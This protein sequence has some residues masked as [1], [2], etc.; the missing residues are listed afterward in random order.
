M[1]TTTLSGH[2]V[3]LRAGRLRLLLPQ[4]SVGAAEYREC[5]P[6]VTA[7]PG[8]FEMSIAGETRRVIFPSERLRPLDQVATPRFVL[9]RL[10]ANS[11]QE[12]WF[13]WDEVRVFINAVF[14]AH[15]LPP[16]LREGAAMPATRYVELQD[17]LVLYA[18][19][20]N[21]VAYLCAGLE[22]CA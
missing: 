22:A 11:A 8:V 21:V 14:T 10:Q 4:A 17:E 2:H 18:D 13:A 6:A 9:T 16:A 12:Y 19:A 15:E 5:E 3:L 20:A 1:E 7:Q